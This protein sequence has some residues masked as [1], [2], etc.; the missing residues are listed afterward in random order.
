MV[1]DIAS[2]YI[3]G[4]HQLSNRLVQNNPREYRD[5]RLMLNKGK[6]DLPVALYSLKEDQERY[7]KEIFYGSAR[8]IRQNAKHAQCE[9][10]VGIPDRG[11]AQGIFNHGHLRGGQHP[12]NVPAEQ[13]LVPGLSHRREGGGL[14]APVPVLCRDWDGAGQRELP[15]PDGL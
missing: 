1:K 10:G 8:Q 5:S 14:P 11:A 4:D 15:G 2:N 6:R 13:G 3:V 7:Y 9:C 12:V